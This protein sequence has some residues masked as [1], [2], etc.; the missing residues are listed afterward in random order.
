MLA[1]QKQPFSWGVLFINHSY[2]KVTE[3]IHDY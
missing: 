2:L 1:I 3:N